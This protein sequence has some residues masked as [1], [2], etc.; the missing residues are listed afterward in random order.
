MFLRTVFLGTMLLL[1]ATLGWLGW[2]LLE[3]D[4][5]LAAQRLAEQ[6]ESGA[7]LAVAALEKQIAVVEQALDRAMV[8]GAS[9]GPPAWPD[10]LVYFPELHE[11][12]E[13]PAGIFEAADALE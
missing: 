2:R 7:D 5:Q 12:T 11:A 6:R 4:R 10:S 1:A 13:A 3:Q 8:S 9:S